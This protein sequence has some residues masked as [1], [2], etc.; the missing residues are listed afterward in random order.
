MHFPQNSKVLVVDDE[1]EEIKPL[2]SVFSRNGISYVYFDGKKHSI[3]KKPLSA[4]RFV[5]LD[6]DLNGRT[7]NLDE[8]SKASA[9]V[10]YLTQLMDIKNTPYF[11][12]FWT[13]HPE[14]IPY[15]LEY[16]KLDN[17][18]PVAY[19]D[20]EKP[21][22][23]EFAKLTLSKLEKMFFSELKD[24]VFDFFITWESNLQEEISKYSNSISNIAKEEAAG[25]NWN[26]SVKNILTKLACSY[27]GNDTLSNIDSQNAL[28]YATN[29][30]N[31]GVS[32]SL[33]S[34]G[35]PDIKM[36]L[37]QKAVLSL[38]SIAKLNKILFFEDVSD[39]KRIANGR[40]W[41]R[42]NEPLFDI[43]KEDK[44]IKKFSKYG[45][46]ELISVVLTPSCDIAHNKNLRK[47]T[48]SGDKTEC[49]MHRILYGVKIEIE[50]SNYHNEEFFSLLKKGHPENVY[51]IQ[52]FFENDKIFIII[53]HFDTICSEKIKT[54]NK[55][56]KTVFKESLTF[57][58]QTKLA[59][60]VNRLG[61]SMLEYNK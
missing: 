14:I 48:S 37:S 38:N 11:L 45:K 3:P 36:A 61:N 7:T 25:G 16:L 58:L 52:P 19:K 55:K 17:F 39:T 34:M 33:S 4:I 6:I 20:M 54:S 28:S 15:I 24:E 41:N 32:E 35:T 49:E 40:I 47:L 57:D 56:C 50:D 22:R 44:T 30:L 59:N 12:L 23:Q 60:H 53:F 8:K 9:L 2:L 26:T 27:T 31:S 29:I 13:K 43:L 46:L 1:Y 51:L 42:K 18:S 10:Q 5:V 21:S